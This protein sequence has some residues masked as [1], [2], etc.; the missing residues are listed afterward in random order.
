MTR[1]SFRAGVRRLFRAPLRT[2]AQIDTDADEELRAFLAARVDDL[3][4]RGMSPD[5][6]AREALR[7][8]GGS[9]EDTAASL[10]Q[11]AM[12]RERHMR[13]RELIDDMRQDLRYAVR[14]LRRESGF[15][16]FAI[17]IIALGIGASTTVFSVAS[18]LLLRPLPFADP[19]R[20]VWIANGNEPGL[21]EQTAQVNPYLTLVKENRSFSDIAAYFAFYGVGDITLSSATDAIRVSAVPVTQNFFPLLGVHPLIG[22]NFSRDESAWNGPPAALISYSLWQRRFDGDPGIVGRPITLN[23]APTVVIGVLPRAFDFG[24]IFAP[25]ARIDIFT[26]FPLTKETNQ[27]GNT[28]AVVGRLAPGVSLAKASAELKVLRPRIAAENPNTNR[29]TPVATSLHDHVSGRARAGLMVLGFGVLVVMLIVCANLSNLLLA[30]ATTRQKEMA[31][32][33]ALGAGRR[34]LLRQMLTESVALSLIGAAVGLILALVGTRAIS[35]LDAVSL[36]LLGNVA[37]DARAVIFTIVLAVVVGV[38]FGLVPAIQI[39]EGGV[40]ETLKSAGR[41]A[42]VGRSGRWIRRAL[43]VSEMA[44]ACILLVASGLLMRSFLKVL[45]VDLGFRPDHVIALRVDPDRGRGAFK[46]GDEFVAYI[47]EILRLVRQ[48][49]GVRAATIADG[50]PLGSNRSWGVSVGGRE[51]VPGKW[52]DGFIRVATDGFVQTMGMRLIAGRDLAPSDVATSDSVVLINE[53]AAKR[54][55]HGTDALGKLL[56][57]DG[58]RRVVGIV[59]D[60]KHLSVEGEA[61]NEIYLPLRQEF[62]Y[63]SLTLIVRT[64]IEPTALASSLRRVLAPIAPNLATNEV[65]TLDAIV[66]RAVSPRRFFTALLGG[67][68]IFALCLALL[69]IYSVI[70]YTVTHRTQEIGVRI[71]LGATARRVQTDIIRETIELTS[72]GLLLGLAGAWL[73]SHALT[74][75]LFGVTAGDPVTYGAMVVVLSVVAI[76]SGYFPARRAARI[77]PIVALRET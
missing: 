24:S 55:W 43:V 22:R 42:M 33:A 41:S 10:H 14:T 59:Q 18:A 51:Y 64:N 30:R 69:G 54:F 26:P 16:A 2:R 5:E 4:A 15:S 56:R 76:A 66:D 60:V 48:I 8:L 29:F 75:F 31:I 77:D 13:V 7:R 6:A 34:R 28:L 9:V 45:D 11:S 46:S 61:G 70:S 44:L 57:V 1:F 23:G 40:H 36:P 73:A 32:R 67:F 52:E 35:H 53:T 68:S 12:N 21:S 3:V 20:L 49:P 25:G 74:G 72:V 63:S 17:A 38:A 65:Q 58:D 62:D 71:A 37:L 19:Q 50:L 39:S 47:D 27:W